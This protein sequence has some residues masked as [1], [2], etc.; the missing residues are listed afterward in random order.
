MHCLRRVNALL[1]VVGIAAA[2]AA[3]CHPP[4][5]VETTIPTTLTLQPAAEY[6]IPPQAP[7]GQ[8]RL[9]IAGVTK[10]KSPNHEWS[11][12]RALRLDL[13]I[14]N[15]SDQVWVLNPDQ[16]IGVLNGTLHEPPISAEANNGVRLGVIAV[17]PHSSLRVNLYYP[18]PESVASANS[19]RSFDVEWRVESDHHVVAE[20]TLFGH[21]HASAK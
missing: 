9:A 16:Q 20:R 18:V 17:P 2:L 1:R 5:E 4:E 13:A 21:R 6:P 14:D 8:L 12:V 10:L 3:G 19:L 7:Q 11:S 15:R